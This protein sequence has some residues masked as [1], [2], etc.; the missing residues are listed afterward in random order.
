[1]LRAVHWPDR[2]PIGQSL[3]ASPPRLG[4]L[5]NRHWP[6]GVRDRYGRRTTRSPTNT[7]V[8][9][10]C[11]AL[12]SHWMRLFEWPVGPSGNEK[13]LACALPNRYRRPMMAVAQ[14]CNI[15]RAVRRE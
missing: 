2:S 6:L 1:M 13:E 9:G 3:P 4:L 14:L 12:G 5:R 8:A 15:L 10:T 11:D 7:E